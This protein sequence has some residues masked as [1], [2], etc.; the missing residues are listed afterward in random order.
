MKKL[1]KEEFYK[2]LPKKRMGSGVIFFNKKDEILILKPTYKDNWTLPGGVVEVNESPRETAIR[3][4]KEEI[5]LSVKSP[6]FFG[7]IYYPDTDGIKGE[8]LQ[9]LFLGGVL[10]D[11]AI[12]KI[13]VDGK[14]IASFRFISAKVTRRLGKKQVGRSLAMLAPKSYKDALAHAGIYSEG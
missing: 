1:S 10:S 7:L 13:K 3:E 14:E 2:N 8:S 6:K 5:G 4:T 9:F 12:K 11:S